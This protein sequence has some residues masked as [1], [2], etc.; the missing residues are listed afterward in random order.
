MHE[1]FAIVRTSLSA[2]AATEEDRQIDDVANIWRSD[3]GTN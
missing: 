1:V 2:N 3:H